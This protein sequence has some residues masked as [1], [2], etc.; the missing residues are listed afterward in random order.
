MSWEALNS[1]K[2]RYKNRTWKTTLH[3]YKKNQKIKI[4][5]ECSEGVFAGLRPRK[6]NFFRPW[7]HVA[8][9]GAP[10]PKKITKMNAKRLQNTPQTS[11]KW[12]RNGTKMAPK[13]KKIEYNRTARKTTKTQTPQ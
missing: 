9:Q 10:R 13:Q 1:I 4:F 6:S 5:D 2:K 7:N 3:K 12:P 11:P 8:P